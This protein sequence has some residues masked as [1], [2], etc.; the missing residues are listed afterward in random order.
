[1]LVAARRPAR[2]PSG[3]GGYARP[4]PQ[5]GLERPGC[6]PLADPGDALEP[7]AFHL[8][9]GQP[10]LAEGCG[11]AGP[12]KLHA[13]QR[14]EGSSCSVDRC[15]VDRDVAAI[16]RSI[17]DPSVDPMAT[18]ARRELGIVVQLARADRADRARCGRS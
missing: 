5:V 2:L 10:G 12:T 16:E 6:Q 15:S 3:L 9:V 4:E 14:G 1:M 18:L 8:V 11:E 17:S 13:A 7:R